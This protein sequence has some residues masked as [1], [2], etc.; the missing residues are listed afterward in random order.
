MSIRRMSYR[1]TFILIGFCFL[2]GML[3]AGA[4]LFGWSY[5]SLEGALTSCSVEW[6]E[7]SFSVFSYNIFIFVCSFLIP[8]IIIV[9]TNIRL[10]I[11]VK[12]SIKKHK[13]SVKS[14]CRAEKEKRLTFT[15]VFYIGMFL[16]QYFLKAFSDR[17]IFEF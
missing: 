11:I 14:R 16:E 13:P 5:Y 7:R 8:F 15:M 12:K 3:C 17:L 2:I 10:L 1:K 4:P 9:F 6:A